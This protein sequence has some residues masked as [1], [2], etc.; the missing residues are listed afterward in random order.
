MHRWRKMWKEVWY[1]H[2]QRCCTRPDRSK[3]TRSHAPME[4]AMISE[5]WCLH[6]VQRCCIILDWSQFTRS[7]AP[8][9]KDVERGMVFARAEMLYQARPVKIHTL[10]RT[11][12]ERYGKRRAVCT[13]RDA[14]QPR[15]VIIHTLSRTDGE[16]YGKRRAVCTCRDAVQPRPVIIHTLSC[17]DGERCGKRRA[18]CLCRDAVPGQTGQNPHAFTH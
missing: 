2:V 17:T 9:E 4:N 16:R 18:V 14:V 8:K 13:C 10:S 5:V 15:P 12:G 6:V 11:Y 1:L 7:H 3:F